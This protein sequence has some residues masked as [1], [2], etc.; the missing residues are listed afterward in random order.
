MAVFA[1]RTGTQ[2][3]NKKIKEKLFIM[4]RRMRVRNR[5]GYDV[6]EAKSKE[7]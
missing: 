1:S 4:S 6:S 7:G 2:H 3:R 5:E